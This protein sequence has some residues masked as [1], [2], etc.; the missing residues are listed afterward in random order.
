MFN[1]YLLNDLKQPSVKHRRGPVSETRPHITSGS[2]PF[3]GA[4]A[5][6]VEKRVEVRYTGEMK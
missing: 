6:L 4:K 2:C 5:L 3:Y 1:N